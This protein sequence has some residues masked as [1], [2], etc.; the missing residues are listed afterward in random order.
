ME[1]Q[2]VRHDGRADDA[3]A[4]EKHLPVPQNF[5]RGHET[6]R[7]RAHIGF[8]Q[9]ELDGE[10]HA[11]GGDKREDQRASILREALVLEPEDDEHVGDGDDAAVNRAGCR[12]GAGAR[13][14]R[15]PPPRGRTPRWQVRRSIHKKPY[16]LFAVRVAT[17]LREVA[18]GDHAELDAEVLHQDG[19]EVGK[20]D[21]GQ[22]RVTELRAALEI[23]G[24]VAGSM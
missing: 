15:R 3:D 4:D 10:T 14:P 5:H 20:Q 9:P 12:R 7:D 6:D 22:Q 2:V 11:D 18:L 19:D 17:R 24:P 13:W 16:G 23:R 1:V 21:D 8:R